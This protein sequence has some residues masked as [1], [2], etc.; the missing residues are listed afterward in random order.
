MTREPM[1]DEQPTQPTPDEGDELARKRAERERAS[2]D[3]LEL[4][5]RVREDARRNARRM[6]AAE[7]A[8][9]RAGP[10]VPP[11]TPDGGSGGASGA[12]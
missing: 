12:A 4:R 3:D 8:R 7:R 1:S 11:H 10:P 5:D 2:T 6:A 9:R